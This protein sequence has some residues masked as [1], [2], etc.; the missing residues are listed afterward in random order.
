MAKHFQHKKSLGQHFLKDE[1]IASDIVDALQDVGTQAVVEIGPGLGILTQFLF[2]KY[3]RQLTCVD[4]DDRLAK[5]IPERFSGIGFIHQDVLKVDFENKFPNQPIHLIGNFPYNISTEII[6][7]VI[8]NKNSFQQVVGMFQKEVAQRF[9]AKHGNKVYGVTSVLSQAF[10]QV[11]YLFDVAPHFFDPPP[12]VQSAVIRFTKPQTPYFIKNEKL[13]FT[14]VKAGFGQRRKTLRNALKPFEKSKNI[15]HV[16]LD[17][18]AEQ[19]SVQEWIDMA[20]LLAE[21]N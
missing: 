6:F 13:L 15:H 4:V 20:N 3:N 19:L 17:K 10:Y 9:A 2:K 21:I 12:K 16:I 1:A 14:L 8:E 5:I 18:R 7:K 11:E